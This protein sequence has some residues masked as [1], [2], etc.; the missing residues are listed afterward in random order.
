MGPP[1]SRQSVMGATRD[2]LD[3]RC[4][5]IRCSESD[6]WS[7]HMRRV[8]VMLGAMV[9]V[10]AAAVAPAQ[11]AHRRPGPLGPFTRL[12]VIYQENHSFDNL[13]AGWGR[14]GSQWVDGRGAPG[15]RLRST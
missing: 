14:V 7:G 12:V 11:A 6:G 13:Y 9:L 5:A 4:P 1:G 2:N 15:Y 8:N 10:L 3:Q